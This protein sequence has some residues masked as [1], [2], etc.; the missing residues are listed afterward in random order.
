MGDQQAMTRRSFLNVVGASGAGLAGVSVLGLP[1]FQKLFAETVKDIPVVW[2]PAGSCTGCSVSLLNSLSPTIQDLL[3]GEVVPGKHVALDFHPTV[4]AGQ[5][6]GAMAVVE[7]YK[8][9]EP[10]SFVLVVEGALSTKD[11]GIYC[12]LGEKNGHG[13]TALEH[14]RDLAPKAMAV[15]NIGTCSSYGGIPMAD[16]NPTGI[17][18]VGQ[19]LKDQGIKTPYVNVPG[20]PPH[21]DWFVGTLATVLLG[22]LEMLNV[23]QHGRPLAFYGRLIHDNCQFRG[24]FDKGQFAQAFGEKRCLFKLGCKGP[25]T[26]ADCPHRKW[27]SGTNWCIGCGSP[28][29]GCVEPDFPFK[30]S[31][32]DRVHIHEQT[33]PD[34]YPPIVSQ[35]GEGASPVVTAVLGGAAGAAIGAGVVSSRL[36]KKQEARETD[37]AGDTGA[38]G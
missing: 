27:N 2:I 25:I 18:P 8:N 30:G 10:G 36:K 28:C 9:A 14:V 7:K 17:V 22:G 6:D 11:D 32:Y 20:C 5:G 21:P 31:L 26:N 3:L 19:F 13:I 35:Q 23:D 1:G 4:M 38:E 24:Q 34:Q 33:P 29:V 16:P 15:V 12:E 37:S